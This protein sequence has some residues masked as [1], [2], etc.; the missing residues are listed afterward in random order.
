MAPA[1][2]F[3]YR[4]SGSRNVRL[5]HDL[6]R[7]YDTVLNNM[8][9]V[10]EAASTAE[11][12]TTATTQWIGNRVNTINNCSHVYIGGLVQDYINSSA[13]TMELL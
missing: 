11:K 6:L 5:G 4:P 1:S 2:M 10:Y 12:L 7:V 9:C 13:L 3:L 8:E